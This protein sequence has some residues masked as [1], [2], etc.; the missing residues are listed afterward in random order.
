VPPA[1]ERLLTLDV[2]RGVAVMGILLANIAAFALPGAAYFSP[3]AWGG[4][5]PA[6]TAAWLANFVLVEGKMRG[7]F[8]FLFGAS[9]LLV[10]E[11]AEAAG[12]SP[13]KVHFAR[14]AV[15]LVIGF[16]HLYLI[17]WGDV[18]AHYALV[19]A[20]AFLFHR[21]PAEKLLALGL[22]GIVGTLAWNAMPLLAMI[23]A[24]P[25]QTADQV[26][27][28]EAF[29]RSFGV[30]S[31]EYTQGEIEAM[32]GSWADQIA[33]R[34]EH[35]TSPLVFLM[36]GGVETLTAMVLGMAAFR[37]GFL[38]GAWERR[39]YW[40]WAG[41]GLPIAWAAYLLLGLNTTARGFDQRWVFFASIVGSAPFRILAVAGYAALIILL[42]R[43]GGWLTERLAAV[44]RAAFTNYLGTSIVVTAI[45]YG[46]GLG[47]FGEWNRTTIYVVPPLVW[48]V[49]LLW[50]KPWLERF[51]YGPLEWLWRSLARLQLQP[52]ARR[53]PAVSRV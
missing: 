42:L 12:E 14:M 24:A 52:M 16:A 46:W 40:H 48:L 29:A 36:I 43:P 44:G 32:R 3:L 50:S 39:R 41:I 26:A 2:V 9:M 28:W 25:R 1:G 20:I 37:S 4:A 49:M 45:F 33:W 34:R 10:I 18:L 23:E 8:S 13:A 5:R 51:R 15:L 31:A 11:R 38:T 19:G 17:W 30:P 7:L 22:A 53:E 27:T 6:E 21:L 35:A 47:Q